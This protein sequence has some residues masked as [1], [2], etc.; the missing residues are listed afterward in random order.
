MSNAVR[1]D[2]LE[3]KYKEMYTTHKSHELS[4]IEKQMIRLIEGFRSIALDAIP[5]TKVP[6]GIS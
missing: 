3:A 5:S 4:E 2:K 6:E 1:F